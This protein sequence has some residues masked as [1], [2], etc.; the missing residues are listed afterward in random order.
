MLMLL[1][2]ATCEEKLL[3]ESPEPRRP[4]VG[5]MGVSRTEFR[6]LVISRGVWSLNRLRL[7]ATPLVF[8]LLASKTDS[9]WL[10]KTANMLPI[11]LPG[12]SV[13]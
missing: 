11:S 10:L 9:I 2:V 8:N 5:C 7:P 6:R 4:G 1:G 12:P 3:S 13:S